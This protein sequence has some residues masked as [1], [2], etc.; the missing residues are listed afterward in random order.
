MSQNNA[1]QLLEELKKH[2][3]DLVARNYPFQQ[4]TNLIYKWEDILREDK[5]LSED[6]NM[7]SASYKIDKILSDEYYHSSPSDVEPR[8]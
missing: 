4:L 1:R 3:N 5:K 6:N 8:D 7:I 2:R